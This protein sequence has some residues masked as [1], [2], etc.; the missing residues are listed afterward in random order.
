MHVNE[1][2]FH[3]SFLWWKIILKTQTKEYILW[4]KSEEDQCLSFLPEKVHLS[5]FQAGGTGSGG[6]KFKSQLL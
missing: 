1:R 3:V 4:V 6:E 5:S 2:V